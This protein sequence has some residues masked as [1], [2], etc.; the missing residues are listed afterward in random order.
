ML[1]FYP[2]NKVFFFK[3]MYL[4]TYFWQCWVSV[5][6]HGLSLVVASGTIL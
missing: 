4:F 3:N 1:S 2:S 6:S 5:A